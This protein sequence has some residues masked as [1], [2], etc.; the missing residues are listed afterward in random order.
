MSAATPPGNATSTIVTVPVP[1]LPAEEA[2]ARLA[3]E[4][5]VASARGGGVRFAPHG[6]N[7]RDDVD[8]VLAEVESLLRL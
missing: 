4:G 6:W 5:V 7:S 2:V 8:V 3:A 1:D